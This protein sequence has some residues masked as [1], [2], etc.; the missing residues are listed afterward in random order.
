LA[1]QDATIIASG[2]KVK[3]LNLQKETRDATEQTFMRTLTAEKEELAIQRELTGVFNSNLTLK[4]LEAALA[5]QLQVD[6]LSGDQ[7]EV[8]K[9]EARE[10]DK[11]NFLLESQIQIADGLR[12]GFIGAFASLID[13]TKSA[14]QAFADMAKNML[15]M[16]AQIMAKMLVM[17]L[18]E[19][20][21]FGSFLG[22]EKGGI[23]PGYAKGGYSLNK[24]NYSRGGTARG[25]QSGYAAT[26]HGNEAVVP[27]PD[28]RSIPVTLNGA[29]GQNNNV[30]VNVSMD[31]GGGSQQSS[32]G[33]S[34]QGKRIGQMVASA[35]Q[36]EL[37]YQKR[38]GGI[39][40][41]Y[42]AA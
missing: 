35:V 11:Q 32:N 38:S 21:S 36:E 40:N 20:T 12:N 42:G 22:F 41:P 24:N 14:K 33:N 26:L 15:S 25:P 5:K 31:G 17:K 13:G 1:G 37:Q 8:L 19:G 4:R 39:L 7:M 18:L 29:G 2:E 23:T 10:I 16:L 9:G 34:E 28:N 27:L 3:D 30:V 6:R